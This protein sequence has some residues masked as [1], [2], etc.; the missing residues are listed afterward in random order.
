M[1]DHIR[2][3]RRRQSR[4][5]MLMLLLLV[6]IVQSGGTLL[7]AEQANGTT[8]QVAEQSTTSTAPAPESV[9]T[10][11]T[12]A[13][14]TPAA[15]GPSFSAPERSLETDLGFFDMS[16]VF[17]PLYATVL[18]EWEE[19]GY[20]PV[21]GV[22]ITIDA[23]KYKRKYAS[24]V[25]SDARVQ[26]VRNYA[27]RPGNTLLWLDE[28]TIIEWEV[29]I[30][31]SGL[32]NIA[33][34]YY[35]LEG[36]RAGIQRDLKIDGKYPFNE[37]NRLIF[38]R[39]WKDATNEPKKDNQG[40]DIRPRQI[41]DPAWQEKLVADAAGMYKSPF[42]FYLSAGY[43]TISMNSMREPMALAEIKILSPEILPSYEEVA[44]TY[45][46][47]GYRVAE[48]EMISVQAEFPE[49]KS[50]PT[51]RAEYSKDPRAV[52]AVVDA[53]VLNVFGGSRWRKGEQWA[54]WKFSVPEDGLYKIGMKVLQNSS[55]RLP[56][57]RRITID[58]KIPFA[59]LEEYLFEYDR[60]AY[61]ET[62]G[63]D[64]EPFLFY[65]TK[66]EHTLRMTALVGPMSRT[67]QV[68]KEASQELM[69][70]NRAIVYITGPTP[71]PNFDW[72]I[73]KKIP[74]LLP[75]LQ[76]L[77]DKLAAEVKWI[78]GYAPH[79][80]IADTLDMTSSILN[81]MIR[82]PDSITARLGEFS[83]QDSLLSSWV[84]TLQN[85]PLTIDYFLIA[86]PDEVFPSV[87][88]GAWER[89][90]VG[91]RAFLLSF[92]KNSTG[93]GDIHEAQDDETVILELWVGHNREWAAII[94]EMIEEDFSPMH[95]HKILVNMNVIPSGALDPNS[96]SVLLLS[97]A[98]GKAPDLVFGARSDLPVEFAIRGGA[99]D[100]SQFPDYE[101]VASWFRPGALI[102]FRYKGGNFALPETQS[103]QML[104]YRKD[105]L[106]RYNL[107]VPQTWDDVI[108]MLPTLQQYGMNFYYGGGFTPFLYQ[109]GGDFYFGDGKYSALD[110]PEALAAFRQ[111]TDLYANY[112]VP[113]AA[114]FYN[115]IRTG[116]MP[117][118]IADY[119]L[120]IQLSTAAPELT[121]WWEMKPIPGV[122][123]PDGTIDRTA[124]G[125]ASTCMIFEDSKQKEAAWELLKWWMSNDIQSR[126][127]Q[128]LEAVIGVEARWN[129]ANVEALTNSPYP[130]ADIEAI[131]EQWRW[132][133]EQPIVLGGYFTTRH[134]NNAWNRV[135]LE[136]VNPREALEIAVKDIDRELAKK[137]EEFGEAV[138]PRKQYYELYGRSGSGL[139]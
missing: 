76:A 13:T 30:P 14:E 100:L 50:D 11:D 68:L 84:L 25:G 135:V 66:G 8:D 45:E 69:L 56:S 35:P 101:E 119:N 118:G 6:V 55:D 60:D 32:Y 114:S 122:R 18:K 131:L 74:E 91:L 4:L 136:G 44:A 31:K 40:N 132:L 113:V 109:H 102:P 72:E 24:E 121:G 88:A 51:I 20:Q 61:I 7:H 36:K 133:R 26:V 95:D 99:Y 58:G 47:K 110:T 138:L 139:N 123:K 52:P 5:L 78:R 82:K 62:L 41:E 71:D 67:I 65:L 80:R 108:E 120:Y 57:V 124:Q 93:I 27:G 54:E 116:E 125:G 106:Q 96:P 34:V 104:F 73:H 59:E 63:K 81:S 48:V 77:A 10:E 90:I 112:R 19:A 87:R 17:D 16:E 128:E 115:R 33:L 21:T 105:I 37:A 70:L 117:I 46:S 98:A 29:Y 83:T 1:A 103:F 111:W 9:A 97:A 3:S 127:G 92:V 75:R 89:F 43:H 39:G 28:E 137:N 23:T 2:R 49:R 85:S 107:P 42:M 22:N 12:P 86:S 79:A 53:E 38:E 126:F 15:D 64:G 134:L 129:T 130:K 94:K